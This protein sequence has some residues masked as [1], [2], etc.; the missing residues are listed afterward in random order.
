MTSTFC[1][2]I[3]LI[4]FPLLGNVDWEHGFFDQGSFI[5]TLGNWAQTIVTGRARLGGIPCGIVAVETRSV[6]CVIPADPANPDSESKVCHDARNIR[7]LVVCANSK[8][9][10]SMSKRH[11]PNHCN[12][13][14]QNV[15]LE[16]E[17]KLARRGTS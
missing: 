11:L 8:V 4:S 15:R 13:K 16:L 6:E 12:I 5:E 10:L 9:W 7:G 14:K 3:S 1:Y 2:L 17:V